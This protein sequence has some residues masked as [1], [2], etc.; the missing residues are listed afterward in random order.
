MIGNMLHE[1]DQQYVA[2][3]DDTTIAKVREIAGPTSVRKEDKETHYIGVVSC[4]FT[5]NG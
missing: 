5:A 2:T 4:T 3:K 1:R